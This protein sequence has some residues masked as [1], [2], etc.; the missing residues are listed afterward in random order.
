MTGALGAGTIFSLAILAMLA[1]TATAAPAAAQQQPQLELTDESVRPLNV[2]TQQ[3]VH[4]AV[5][6]YVRSRLDGKTHVDERFDIHIR[7]Q[8]DILLD[9]PIGRVS[10]EVHPVSPNPFRGPAV[11]RAEI[12]VNERTEK[13]LTMTVDTRFYRD[14]LVTTRAVRRG[15]LF[16]DDM[17]ELEERDVTNLRYGY[18]SDVAALSGMQARRPVGAGA[19]VNERH[20]EL[21][22]VVKR[23][24]GITMMAQSPNMQISASGVALQDGGMG[25]HIRVKNT[26]SGKIV[27]GEVVDAGTVQ[28]GS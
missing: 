16:A 14:V 13:V 9:A 24:D 17:V 18:F 20:V 19:V 7:W 3:A 5:E 6:E 25:E 21:I 15:T 27:I 12:L 26:D 10:F 2:I 23:G 22:P 8:G 1:L 28:V 4:V 11:V